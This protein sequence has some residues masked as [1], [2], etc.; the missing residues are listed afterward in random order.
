MKLGIIGAGAVGAAVAMAV[1]GRG[2]ACEIVLVD[3]NAA[4]ARGVATDLR[5]G[6]PVSPLVEVTAGD[7]DAI[8]DADLVIITA[9]INEQAGGATNRGDPMG[10]LRLLDANV[11]VFEDVVPRIVAVAPNAPILVVS[12]PPEPLVDIARALAGH[13][14]VLST[15]TFLDTLRFRVH[16]GEQFGVSP[17]S[18][19]ANVI[20]E[21]GTQNVFVWSTASIGGIRV[22]DLAAARGL[23]F[24]A[25]RRS[26]EESV[27]Y[28]NITIIEGIGASQYGIGIVTARVA[29]I[30][31]RNERAIIP[32][33]SYQPRYGITLSLPTV[34]GSAGAVEVLWPKLDPDEQAA[35]DATAAR[36][37]EIGAKYAPAGT[38]T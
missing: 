26:I 36:L 4:R 1:C 23:D 27:R 6:V 24:A 7:Y 8:A 18:I 22:T 32:V 38:R 17:A 30:I 10:R 15:S 12:N 11:G 13:E 37:K 34:V 29:E 20:G 16:L 2:H 33:G 35:L 9:G 19:H 28:A 31:V 14:R 5:Y 21:H 3:K 25:F